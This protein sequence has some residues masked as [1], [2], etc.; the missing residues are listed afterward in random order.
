MWN[1]H[2]KLGSNLQLKTDTWSPLSSDKTS[3]DRILQSVNAARSQV[4]ANM[5]KASKFPLR[6]VGIGFDLLISYYHI[7]K[8]NLRDLIAETDLIFL[9]KIG[10][11]S[12]IFGPMWLGNLMEDLKETIG[13]LLYIIMI[14]SSF[15]RHF[16]AIVEFKLEL[17]SGNAQFGSKLVIFCPL[18]PQN[19]T[20]DLEKQ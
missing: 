15:V 6:L 14:M 12:L 3:N 20:N 7:N 16:K 2:S 11:K 19:L 4:Q 1:S 13:H 10:F 18:W 5:A 9:L 8:A 17:Q